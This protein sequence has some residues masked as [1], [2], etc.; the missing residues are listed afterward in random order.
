MKVSIVFFLF[1]M[2]QFTD[3]QKMVEYLRIETMSWEYCYNANESFM[4]SYK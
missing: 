1:A 2:D 4:K 3:K